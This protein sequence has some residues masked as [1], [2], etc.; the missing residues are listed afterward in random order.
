MNQPNDP[1]NSGASERKLFYEKQIEIIYQGYG[2]HYTDIVRSMS[3]KIFNW[4]F[5]LNTGGLAVTITFM[6]AAIKWH[7]LTYAG[8]MPFVIMIVIYGLGIISI[9][10]AAFFEHVR[11][12]KKGHLLDS[13]YDEFAEDKITANAFIEKLPPK[14]CCYDWIVSKLEKTSYVLFL[15][16]LI[17]AMVVLFYK[18]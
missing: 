1:C 7:S 16:G 12:A 15:I 6:G 17:S 2:K 11:F 8:L 13:F 14:I 9:V 18:V 4:A 3:D 5:T 10:F